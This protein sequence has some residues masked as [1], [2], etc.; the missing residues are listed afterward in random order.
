MIMI[1]CE[2]IA[3]RIDEID[4]WSL[5]TISLSGNL[6]F[7]KSDHRCPLKSRE[8]WATSMKESFFYEGQRSP[9]RKKRGETQLKIN[10]RETAAFV[11]SFVL[12]FLVFLKKKCQKT[13]LSTT[14]KNFQLQFLIILAK[15]QPQQKK[16][17]KSE[18]CRLSNVL[19]NDERYPITPRKH[20]HKNN[21]RGEAVKSQ[22]GALSKSSK[23]IVFF[24]EER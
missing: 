13:L 18:R 16:L 24:L 3:G 4:G 15:Q 20:Q 9:L 23:P 8:L 11:R 6:T 12:S 22:S 14:H 2:K 5:W 21:S 10:H 17:R 19:L 7:T 1:V